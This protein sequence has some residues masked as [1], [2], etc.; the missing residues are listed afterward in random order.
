MLHNR[1]KTLPAWHNKCNGELL[2]RV[3]VHADVLHQ[4]VRLETGFHLAEGDV[5][6]QL[7]LHEILLTIDQLEAA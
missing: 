7:Q 2:V 3:S 5:L 6:A 4:R 1:T